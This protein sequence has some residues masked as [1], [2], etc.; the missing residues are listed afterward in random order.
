MCVCVCRSA[1]ASAKELQIGVHTLTKLGS[2]KTL[3]KRGNYNK[4]SSYAPLYYYSAVWLCKP[5]LGR[6]VQILVGINSKGAWGS[7]V[8]LK[9]LPSGS[10][11]H[12]KYLPSGSCA[13]LKYFASGSCAHLKYFASSSCAH[14]K[15]FASSSCAHLKYFASGSCAHLKYFS[16]CF[17]IYCASMWVAGIF[18]K[19]KCSCWQLQFFH[20]HSS[21]HNQ[22]CVAFMFFC[23]WV[24]TDT[25]HDKNIVMLGLE[26]VG[27]LRVSACY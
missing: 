18:G 21:Q 15:Y 25:L 12:L 9:Y 14:L 7:C 27:S 16:G 5:C 23:F 8:H 10:C 19:R 3:F 24:N 6:A 4:G 22:V 11:A 17:E 20:W 13:H 2:H 26:F 1:N